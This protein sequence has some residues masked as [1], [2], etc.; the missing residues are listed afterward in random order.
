[1][2]ALEQSLA[3]R[4]AIIGM[5]HKD[6]EVRASK[7]SAKWLK[8]SD[9]VCSHCNDSFIIIKVKFKEGRRGL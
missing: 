9:T 5:L 2:C 6:L 8:R 4:D 3:E 1:M 7:F